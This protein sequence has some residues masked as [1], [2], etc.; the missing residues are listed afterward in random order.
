MRICLPSYLFNFL[1]LIKH[2][3]GTRAYIYLSQKPQFRVG[4]KVYFEVGR[5]LQ[6]PYFVATVRPETRCYTLSGPDG[7][8]VRSG[9]EVEEKALSL[10][11][12]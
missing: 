1:V 7:S 8:A 3:N 4:D 10:A 12:Q 6:G 2:D 11:D 5:A 9:G